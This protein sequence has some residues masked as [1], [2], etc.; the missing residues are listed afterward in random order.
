M[1]MFLLICTH[2][3]INK[4]IKFKSYLLKSHSKNMRTKEKQEDKILNRFCHKF[5]MKTYPSI[6]E[7]LKILDYAKIHSKY[8]ASKS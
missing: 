3:K 2:F 8:P 6:K 1:S 4:H 7:K 5:K